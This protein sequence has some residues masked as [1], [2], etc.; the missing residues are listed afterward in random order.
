MFKQMKVALWLTALLV[1]AAL[2]ACQPQTQ[3]VEVTRVVTETIT[4]EGQEVEVTRVV[5]EMQEVVV[6]STP[7][8]M[9]PMGAADPTTWREVS[10]GEPDSLDPALGYETSGGNV[11]QNVMEPLIIYDHVSPTDF[12]PALAVEVPSLDNGGISEDGRTYTFQIRE[13][14]TFHA[15]GTLEPHDVAYSFQ[16]GLLQ[17]DPNGPQWLLMEPIMGFASGDITEAIDPEGNLIGDP[18]A[19]QALDAEQLAAV[20]EAV[21]AAVVADDAAGT[22]T[23]NLAVPWGPFLAT[24]TSTWGSILDME[25]AVEQGAWDGDCATWQNWY[26]PGVENSELTPII[27]GTGPFMLD[28]WTPGEEIVLT[29]YENYWRT[30][31]T[32]KWEG[33]PY[34]PAALKTVIYS[35]VDEWGTRL[36][37][38]QAGDAEYVQVNPEHEIQ[39]DPLVGVIC[40]AQTFACEPNPENPEGQFVKYVNRPGVNRTDIFPTF[41]IAEGSPYVGSGA[42]DGNGIPLDFFSDLNVRQ[43]LAT[44]FNYEV[45]NEEVLLGQ[46]VRN[47]GTIIK[48]MLGYNAVSY[49]HLDVY[50]RQAPTS[51]ARMSA[52]S[53]ASASRGVP[54]SPG[55]G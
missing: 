2:A 19:V 55:R 20:C 27:N 22:V 5:T 42:L 41:N 13:G 29:A 46:G 35:V 23:F 26:A 34:G 17:S 12:V 3:V 52:H 21:Q 44:C 28:H 4:E 1:L 9:A 40:D 45:Y 37:T 7:E 50:K 32:P 14:V 51:P 39:V 15:G 6:T 30:A 10:F 8:A 49:T 33:G 36:A 47:N 48:G 54:G 31:E 38:F 43:A 53:K 16:R 11:I 24:L 25:W 18:A